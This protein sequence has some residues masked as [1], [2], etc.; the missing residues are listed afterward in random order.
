M[1]DYISGWND[2]HEHFADWTD[3]TV[4]E[5]HGLITG[6]LT[7]C[8]APTD[9]QIWQNLLAE[10]SFSELEPKTLEFL[11]E[12][13]EDL[14]A[15]LSDDE[16]RYQFSPLLPDD[17]HPLFERLMALSDWANGFMTGFGVTDSALR[18]E[19]NTLFNDLAKIG[20]LRIDE[21][22]ESLQG[23]ASDE[24]NPEGEVEY[25]ELLEFVRMIPVSVAGGRVRKSVAK[26][27]LIAGFAMNRPIG[28]TVESA[29]E[30]AHLDYLESLQD[31]DEL[32]WQ[33]EKDA[34]DDF[35]THM[36]VDAMTG[37][38]PS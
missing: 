24:I 3:V 19:E 2:W 27:P 32:A 13:A 10:L 14:S 31:D 33:A 22:D 16:D 1:D 21:L 26:L 11:A 28:K 4:S 30:Q 12:E 29:E 37:K 38:K 35:V 25:M 34:N 36:V 6:I 5:L 17:E 8:D 7:A 20:A 18:P 23:T 9:S 15:T